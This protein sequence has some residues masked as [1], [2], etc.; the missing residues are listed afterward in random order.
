MKDGKREA[1]E[2]S[3]IFLVPH[4]VRPELVEGKRTKVKGNTNLRK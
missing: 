2:R 3:F 4:P 1:Q